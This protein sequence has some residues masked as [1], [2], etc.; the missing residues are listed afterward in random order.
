MAGSDLRG[1]NLTG[2]NL[3]DANLSGADLRGVRGMTPDQIKSVAKID[4]NTRF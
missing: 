3:S 2:A 4:S 1:V